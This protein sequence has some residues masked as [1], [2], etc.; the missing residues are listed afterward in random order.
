MSY[1]NVAKCL[2]SNSC[3]SSGS[4]Y[5]SITYRY[6][7]PS[8]HDSAASFRHRTAHPCRS[9]SSNSSAVTLESGN[10]MNPQLDPQDERMINQLLE[11]KEKHGDCHVPSGRGKFAKEE[12]ER[13]GVSD[14]LA[15][16]VAKQRTSYRSFQRKKKIKPSD[17]A[18]QIK[19]LLL[20]SM[21]FMWSEREA[22][23][24]RSFNRLEAYAKTNNGS[25]YVDRNKDFHLWTWADQQRKAYQKGNLPD[26]RMKLLNEIAFVF[27]V[28]EARWWDF[29]DQLCRYKEE[30]G[31][32][33]V[34]T[35]KQEYKH[36]GPWV[37]RQRRRYVADQ[38]QDDRVEALEKIG[39]KC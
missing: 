15:T 32:T 10:G 19:I 24:Q 17:E 28:Q 23:W 27:D 22:Q 33:V 4:T 18:F 6:L 39:C 29:Y 16:W 37:A 34:P 7:G 26:E 8:R 21:G 31:D 3:C 36:L 14:E 13:L 9:I 20:E 12:R 1:N 30:H 11:Y 35:Y 25:V 2:G 5:L 38:L